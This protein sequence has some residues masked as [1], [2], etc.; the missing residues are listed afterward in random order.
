MTKNYAH[1][2]PKQWP[3]TRSEECVREAIS[4]L[5]EAESLLEIAAQR[6]GSGQLVACC[7]RILCS[8]I[9]GEDAQRFLEE[10]AREER[11]RLEQALESLPIEHL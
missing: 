7:G 9:A 3:V 4:L 1:F 10:A 5:R 6:T 11:A 8:R 2:T